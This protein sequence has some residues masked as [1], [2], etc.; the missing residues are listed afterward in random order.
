MRWYHLLPLE[1]RWRECHHNWL[2]YD[3][4]KLSNLPIGRT[5]VGPHCEIPMASSTANRQ[6]GKVF[7]RSHTIGLRRRSADRY[8]SLMFPNA[9]W[10]NASTSSFS[11]IDPWIDMARMFYFSKRKP[12]QSSMPLR[13]FA[14][15]YRLVEVQSI[16]NTMTSATSWEYNESIFSWRMRQWLLFAP[17]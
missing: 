2:V 5:K 9:H 13:L 4:V 10:S 12:G 11:S 3:P 1:L 17:V 7:K 15:K 6:I 16:E 14:H 8:K